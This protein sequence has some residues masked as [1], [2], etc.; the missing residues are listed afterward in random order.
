MKKNQLLHGLLFIFMLPLIS[1]SQ[2]LFDW[3]GDAPDGNWKRGADGGRWFGTSGTSD[4]TGS[5]CWDEPPFGILR[6]NNNSQLNMNNNISGT[7]SL[8]QLLFGS[9]GSSVRTLSGNTIRFYDLSTTDPK[10]ENQSVANHVINLNIEGDGNIDPLEINPVSG[11]LTFNGTIDNKG[12]DLVIWGENSNSVKFNGVISG[13]GKLTI[14]QNS[15][16]KINAANT[17]TGNTEIDKGE[18]WIESTGQIASS[19]PIYVGN[20]SSTDN[21]CKLWLSNSSGGNTF[22]NNIV[23]NNGNSNK[24]IIG[25]FNTSGTHTFSGNITNNSTGGLSLGA[26]QAGGTTL[27]SGSISGSY[28]IQ[29]DP[30]MSGMVELTGQNTY[31]GNTTVNAGTL[32]F[33]RTGGNT[34]PVGSNVT[35]QNGGTLRVSTDQTLNNLTINAGGTLIVDDGAT[36]TVTGT[37]IYNGTIQVKNSSFSASVPIANLEV[38]RAAGVSLGSNV[39]VTGTLTLTSGKLS[40]GNNTL[41]ISNSATNAISGGNSANYIVGNLKRAV[42]GTGNYIFPIGTSTNYEEASVNFTTGG[43]T[44]DIT[45]FFTGTA[46]SSITSGLTVSGTSLTGAL[47]A[48]YW[49]ISP[50]NSSGTPTYTITLKMR[51]QSNTAGNA[52]KYS[53]IKRDNSSSP[54]TTPGTHNNNTQS[55]SGGTITAVRSGLTSF[56]DYTI[57]Y[58]SNPLPVTFT[59]LTGNIRNGRANL[60]WTIADEHNVDHYEVEES[61]NGRQFLALTQVDASNRSSYQAIDAQLY[62]GTNY[63]RVKA[64]DIDGKLTYSKIIRLENNA[65][66]QQIRVYPNPSQGEL[67]L[68]MNVPAGNYQI[69]MINALGQTVHQQSLIH[70]G[71]SRSMPLGLPKLNA[72]IYQVEVRGGV[73]KLVKSLRIE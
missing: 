34:I 41:Y 69:R 50:S 43:F 3:K 7:Y 58:S 32:R 15:I 60:S 59:S 64:V 40:T 17:F 31:T 47:D 36:L 25:A 61:L 42:A 16:A 1:N 37:A 6:F 8:H 63:Y 29:T 12:T 49:T 38:N 26:L 23:I 62:S 55:E 52:N 9:S 35:V 4:C 13:A 18:I 67:N 20:A 72:G 51:G 73:Q 22:P 14:K 56:S 27:F 10:I 53:I 21:L 24:R 71:G 48:G 33:N 68:S 44:A 70:E 19:N 2:P 30:S 57:A 11:N 28:P 5:G 39:S 65:L 54:W 66:D 45:A 46:I